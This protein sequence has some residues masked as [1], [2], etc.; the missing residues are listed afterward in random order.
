MNKEILNIIHE[1][2]NIHIQKQVIK[3]QNNI[4][5]HYTNL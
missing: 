2:I 3:I 4:F 1:Y 5:I